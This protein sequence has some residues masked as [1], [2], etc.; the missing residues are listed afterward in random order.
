M[1]L[2]N[3]EDIF[4]LFAEGFLIGALFSG[5]AFTIGWFINFVL[6]LVKSA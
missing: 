1:T 2:S 3:L 6:A 4:E 5:L